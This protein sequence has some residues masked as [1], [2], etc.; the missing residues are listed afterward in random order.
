MG[1]LS[2]DGSFLMRFTKRARKN[3]QVRSRKM[4]AVV[5]Y[6]NN[7]MKH[8]TSTQEQ[9]MPTEPGEQRSF[10]EAIVKEIP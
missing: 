10:V 1:G 3:G 2:L 4:V 9:D 5:C 8:P 6:R 7:E